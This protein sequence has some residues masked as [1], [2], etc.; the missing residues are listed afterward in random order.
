[1]RLL[2]RW[3]IG[4]FYLNRFK[5]AAAIC[6]TI[7]SLGIGLMGDFNHSLQACALRT[8]SQQDHVCPT[9]LHADGGLV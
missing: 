2:S 4:T 1:M 9:V 6:R 5:Q 3:Q 7:N 8:M